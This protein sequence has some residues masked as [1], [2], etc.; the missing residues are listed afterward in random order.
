MSIE[1]VSELLQLTPKIKLIGTPV[2]KSAEFMVCWLKQTVNCFLPG[3]NL[4]TASARMCVGIFG[5]V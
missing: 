5:Y 4:V 3:S 1:A 2:G